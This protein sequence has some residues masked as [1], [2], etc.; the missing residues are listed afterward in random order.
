MRTAN[1]LMRDVMKAAQHKPAGMR[2]VAVAKRGRNKDHCYGKRTS[3]CVM[4]GRGTRKR[5]R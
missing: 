3:H 1:K 2:S 4:T 5:S